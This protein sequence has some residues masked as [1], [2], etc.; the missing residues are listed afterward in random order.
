MQRKSL[1][2]SHRVVREPQKNPKE[3][4]ASEKHDSGDAKSQVHFQF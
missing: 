2:Q 1:T 4:V 3:S